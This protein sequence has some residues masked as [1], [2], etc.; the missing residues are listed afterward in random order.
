MQTVRRMYWPA[1]NLVGPGA[2]KEIGDEVLK[3]GLKKA[4]VVTDKVLNEL[5]VAKRLTDILEEKGISY[6]IYDD[7]Q[8][9]PTM[10]NCHDGLEKYNV[11]N[12]DFIISLGGGSPQDCAKAIGILKTNG[13]KISDYE[14][15]FI[16]HI[17][18]LIATFLPNEL[19]MV[20]SSLSTFLA[21]N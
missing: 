16:S 7:V 6:S 20:S 19:Q 1:L 2:L 9:N 10:K 3:L 13:G 18:K 17:V 12:C 4:F 15:V 11:E 5:G 8:P 21:L 14:G